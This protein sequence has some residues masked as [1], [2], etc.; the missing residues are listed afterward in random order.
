[1]NLTKKA[2]EAKK[3][4]THITHPSNKHLRV[5][6][7]LTVF[8]IRIRFSTSLAARCSIDKGSKENV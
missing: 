5:D 3:A 6:L 4:K 2:K 7:A 8:S 1:M